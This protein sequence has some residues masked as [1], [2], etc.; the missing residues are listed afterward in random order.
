M[1]HSLDFPRFGHTVNVLR[2]TK[3][4]LY[5]DFRIIA[6]ARKVGFEV[7]V[8]QEDNLVSMVLPLT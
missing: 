2:V 1:S 4:P 3:E 7:S 8:S 5:R 6:L